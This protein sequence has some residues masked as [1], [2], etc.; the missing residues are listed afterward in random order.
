[1]YLQRTLEDK[2]KYLFDNYQ[3]PILL[4]GSRQ[5]GKTTLIKKCLENYDS[6]YINLAEDTYGINDIFQSGNRLDIE[7]ILEEISDKTNREITNETI[8]FVDEIQQNYIAFSS[9]K[10]FN[11][12]K[13]CK[14][15]C[16]GSNVGPLLFSDP[17]VL[18]PVGQFTSLHLHPFSFE[19]FLL[20]TGNKYYVDKLLK[21]LLEKNISSTLH[22]ELLK[23]FDIYL[24][25]GGLPSVIKKYVNEEDYKLEQ[26][27][28][29][30]NYV[31]DFSKYAD[32]KDIVYLKK[33]YSEIPAF[34]GTE[35]QIFNLNK[36]GRASLY[37]DAVNWIE[38]SRMAI[39]C[40]K[41][42][43]IKRPLSTNASPTKFKL[44]LNDTGLLLNILDYDID[45]LLRQVDK[46][47]TGVI[48]ENYL[49]TVLKKYTDDLMFY[50]DGSKEVD[51][52]F[53]YNQ[54]IF[55]IEV[56]ASTNVKSKALSV[57]IDQYQDISSYKISRK[58]LEFSKFD[59][60]PFYAVDMILDHK[61]KGYFNY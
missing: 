19:E 36:L 30:A 12:S 61:I 2:L 57:L 59:Y 21:S 37:T 3:K 24:R 18:Y 32:K 8:I 11:E 44:F 42:S 48:C 13:K 31:G 50:D 60:L 38:L 56:K 7:T 10:A 55:A 15:I 17:K 47:Y 33:I 52:L 51:F 53:Q 23:L 25:I 46:I 40:N 5:V 54:K 35:K 1:M 26:K 39:K 9:L 16:S 6:I 58:N 28:L 45:L 41:I 20:A 22:E 14:I 29:F 27:E 49:A 43:T 34:L 4:S